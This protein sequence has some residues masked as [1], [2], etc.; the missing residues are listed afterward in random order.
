[1]KLTAFAPLAVVLVAC[2]AT[3]GGAGTSQDALRGSSSDDAP[4]LTFD[5]SRAIVAGT[6]CSDADT[7]ITTSDGGFH[8]DFNA[9]AVNLPSDDPNQVADMRSCLIRVPTTVPKGY[10]VSKLRQK[11]AY[12]VDKADGATAAVATY[13]TL[14]GVGM[15]SKTVQFSSDDGAVSRPDGFW[16]KTMTFGRGSSFYYAS[17]SPNSYSATMFAAS[18]AVAGQLADGDSTSVSVPSFD[19]QPGVDYELSPCE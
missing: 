1:M 6:G 15:P 10:Y 4:L 8:I 9:L 18:L 19:V 12:A 5:F 7:T 11:V 14:G 3:S 16:S 17:C 2:S 13:T